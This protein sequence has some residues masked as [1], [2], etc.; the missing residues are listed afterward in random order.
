MRT[1]PLIYSTIQERKLLA[2]KP[3]L[4][5]GMISLSDTV[6]AVN[7]DDLKSGKE[8]GKVL[9]AD[10]E[11][12]NGRTFNP[13]FME[14]CKTPGND[15][16]II[17]SLNHAEDVFDAFLGN[18]DKVVFP[19]ADMYDEYEFDKILEISDNCIPLLVTGDKR[20]TS[21]NIEEDVYHL[22]S[23]GF[24]NIMVADMDGSVTDDIWNTLQDI[25]GGLI[26]Y[27]PSRQI[28]ADT[29]ILAKDVFSLSVR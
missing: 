23:K 28:G 15:L 4:D 26:S 10:I 16:W 24:S 5:H 1:I 3:A 2:G 19:C 9:V 29:R 11:S 14:Y 27:S 18:A 7:L 21:T 22:S 12:L 20:R 17:E 6:P 13:S 25:C 8:R